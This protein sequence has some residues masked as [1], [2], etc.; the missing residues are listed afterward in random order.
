M[1]GMLGSIGKTGD[2]LMPR[3]TW[4]GDAYNDVSDP[5]DLA[6]MRASE[7]RRETAAIAEQSAQRGIDAN[8]EMLALQN[9]MYQPYRDAA[10]SAWGDYTGMTTGGAGSQPL[11]PQYMQEVGRNTGA[12]NRMMA[13]KGALNSSG[14]GAAIGDVY[15][16][17]GQNEASRQ[18]GRQLDLQ[19]L[20]TGAV[21]RL[22]AAGST[23]GANAGS[24]YG[25]LGNQMNAMYQNYGQQ[26]RDSFNTV[27]NA[28]SGFA[29][30]VGSR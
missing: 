2:S 23:A 28:M 5:F 3:G 12:V 21:E 9:A 16:N 19:R 29:D 6:G 14:R 20:G 10:Q 27:G 17:A 11:S 25:N 4:Y 1:G 8:E 7:S 15:L 13:A 30:Y 18:Y 24:L 26:R 22:G